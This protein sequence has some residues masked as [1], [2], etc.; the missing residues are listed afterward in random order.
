MLEACGG[1]G[2]AAAFV[3]VVV[4]VVYGW[5]F[6]NWVWLK[7]KKKEKC[8]RNQGLKGTSYRF[9][10]GDIKEMVKM[11]TEAYVKPI[12]LN[13]DI[14]PRVMSFAHKF[15]TTHGKNCFTWAGPIPII[16]ITD[17]SMIKEILGNYEDFQ[18]QRGGNPLTRLLAKGLVDVEGDQWVKHRKIINPAFHV[19]KL[20]HMV[21]A[22]YVSCDEMVN[23]WEETLK[24]ESSCEMDVWPHLQALAADVISRTAFG[25]SY[26]EGRKIF[27]LQR[28]QAELIITASRSIYIPGSRFLPTKRNLRIKA[29]AHEVKGLVKGIIDKRVAHMKKGGNSNDDL[30]GILLDSNYKEIKQYGHTKFGLSIDDV[31]EECKLFYFA[32]Q[33]T[34]ANL[35]VWTMIMLGQHISWQNRA[36]DEVLKIFGD[37]KPDIDGLNQLKVINM[38]FLEILRLYPPVVAI[39][40]M[41]HKETKLGNITLPA[42]TFMLLH[43]MLSHHDPNIWGDDVKEFKPERFSQG[44]SKVTKGQTAFIPFGGGPRVCI[45]QNFAMLEAKMTLVMILRRFSFELSPSYTHAPYTIITLQPQFGAH[46]V[47]NKL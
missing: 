10:Y 11:I 3:A 47:L 16:H 42:G 35:L 43:T 21:P 14:V 36:R 5:R 28:E 15:V 26:V 18:K 6:Y 20:K 17:P 39:P 29:I 45:G 33:E 22:F 31:V 8:L 44:V 4:V 2:K 34:T 13:D 1:V 38:I 24:E 27:E 37:K 23:K 40:R 46:L 19:E 25:S 9:L 12:N 7:P 41:I 32:G 30:L